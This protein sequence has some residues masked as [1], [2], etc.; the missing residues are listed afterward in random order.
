MATS[1]RK[2]EFFALSSGDYSDYSFHDLYRALDDIDLDASADAFLP[3]LKARALLQ[4]VT[5]PDYV[6]EHDDEDVID[7]LSDCGNGVQAFG[8]YLIR[9]GLVEPIDY[10][11]IHTGHR[12]DLG[13]LKE[14]VQVRAVNLETRAES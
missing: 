10:D 13:R 1:H 8:A 2:G 5:V 6:D 11:E 14:Y 12:F 3:D 9:Q 7:Y 4:G